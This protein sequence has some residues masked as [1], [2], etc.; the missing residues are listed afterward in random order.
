MM[1]LYLRTNIREARDVSV[2][3]KHSSLRAAVLLTWCCCRTIFCAQCCALASLSHFVERTTSRGAQATQQARHVRMA[4]AQAT[5][6]SLKGSTAI[7]TE[8]FGAPACRL[9]VAVAAADSGCVVRRV[10]LQGTR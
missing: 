7:V 3:V 2:L 10:V 9:C 6:I 1:K 5:P 4:T 8:F